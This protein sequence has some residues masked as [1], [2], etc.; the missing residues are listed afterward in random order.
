[1]LEAYNQ[2]M[3]SPNSRLAYNP[4]EEKSRKALLV[5]EPC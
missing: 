5:S 3:G 1:M 4:L 2:K